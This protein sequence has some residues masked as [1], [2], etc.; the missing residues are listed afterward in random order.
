M[1]HN[2]PPKIIQTI[3]GRKSYDISGTSFLRRPGDSVSSKP[4][5]R[6]FFF[7]GGAAECWIPPE[8]D[9]IQIRPKH[10]VACFSRLIDVSVHIH[11]FINVRF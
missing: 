6:T 11:N 2:I 9:R 7:W 3:D 4:Y 1:I 10:T 5:A 8:I